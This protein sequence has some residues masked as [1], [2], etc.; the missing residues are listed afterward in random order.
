[1]KDR[2][3]QSP[4][5]VVS[6]L[7]SKTIISD[8]LFLGTSLWNHQTIIP[9]ARGHSQAAHLFSL[10]GALKMIPLPILPSI[11]MSVLARQEVSPALSL[12][13]I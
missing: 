3:R 1:M 4:G 8:S 7:N 2:Q 10:L 6:L 13:L 5:L 11:S 9:G 12:H